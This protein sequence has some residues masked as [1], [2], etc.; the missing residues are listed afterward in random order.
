M[1]DDDASR[2]R[3][4]GLFLRSPVDAG[5]KLVVLKALA[6]PFQMARSTP[7]RRSCSAPFPVAALLFLGHRGWHEGMDFVQH[8]LG[9]GYQP[10]DLPPGTVD[11]EHCH[12]PAELLAVIYHCPHGVDEPLDDEESARA[13]V[14]I[15]C[16]ACGRQIQLM[17]LDCN[18]G[19]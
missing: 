15:Q 12:A 11:C 16:P 9:I 2:Y 13:I 3:V 8:K 10:D 1:R 5:R 6:N 14:M 19:E 17:S 7:K 4:G 18:V